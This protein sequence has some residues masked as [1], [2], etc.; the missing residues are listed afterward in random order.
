MGGQVASHP[1]AS[2]STCGI[3]GRFVKSTDAHDAGAEAVAD[4]ASHPDAIHMRNL[5]FALLLG[6]LAGCSA[7]A[8]SAKPRLALVYPMTDSASFTRE[9]ASAAEMDALMVVEYM[10][11]RC[12]ACKALGPK[13]DKLAR[14]RNPDSGTRFFAVNALPAMGRALAD[15]NDVE[16]LPTVAVYKDG[17]KLLQRTLAVKEWPDFVRALE[18]FE[19]DTESQEFGI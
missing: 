18:E 10:Q 14:S 7:M 6:I 1:A 11:P 4:G 16:A 8:I 5:L 15:E 12:V 19:H 17:E 2:F 3:F 13:L 9:L